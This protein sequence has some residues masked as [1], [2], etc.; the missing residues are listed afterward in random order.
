MIIIENK[1]PA[2]LNW[3]CPVQAPDLI[4][5]GDLMDGGYIVP[6]AVIDQADGLLSLGLGD[7]WSFDAAWHSLKPQ[8]AIHMYDGTV[9]RDNLAITINTRVRSQIDIRSAYDQFFQEDRRHFEQ[10]VG[11]NSGQ[12]NLTTCL[13]RLGSKKTF[14]KMDIEG[15]EYALIADLIRH[16][17][18]ITGMVM[19]FHFC[20]SHRNVFETAV[21]ELLQHYSLVHL[22]GNNHVEPGPEGLTDC[23]ELTLVHKDLLT[24]T[25]LRTNFYIDGLDF[26]NKAGDEDYRYCF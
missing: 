25:E 21:R 20:N 13:E 19:E 11:P 22:H 23:L 2:H 10:N 6:R 1:L 18:Q 8:D 9:N 16:K 3:L 12:T 24:S 26:S 5:L 17:D 15:G 14:I 7:N 4:R